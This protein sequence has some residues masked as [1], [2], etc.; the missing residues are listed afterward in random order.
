MLAR[1][2]TLAYLAQRAIARH[3]VPFSI[4]AV[5]LCL[6]VGAFVIALWQARVAARERQR[7]V[8]RYAVRARAR[9][10]DHLQDS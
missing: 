6:L 9:Q 5:S 1:E 3:R 4:A 7:A 8:E 2:P 10:L